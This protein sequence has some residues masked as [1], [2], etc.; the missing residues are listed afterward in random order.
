MKIK[1]I[2]DKGIRP[3]NVDVVVNYN[4]SA[5]KITLEPGQCIYVEGDF[6]SLITQFMRVQKQK[7]LIDFTDEKEPLSVEVAPEII[8]DLHE[9]DLVNETGTLIFKKEFVD[10]LVEEVVEDLA[11]EIFD[12]LSEE[13]VVDIFDLS[14]EDVQKEEEIKEVPKKQKGRPKGSY[15]L[16]SRIKAAQEEKLNK[17]DK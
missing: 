11:Q 16:S 5:K 8:S 13:K 4:K 10:V 9:G 14:L 12:D 17:N 6:N 1:N 7:G 15:K 2:T 3:S